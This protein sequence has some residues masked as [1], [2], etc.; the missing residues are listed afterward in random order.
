MAVNSDSR[1]RLC[2]LRGSTRLDGLCLEFCEGV[3]YGYIRGEG[4][5]LDMNLDAVKLYV[6]T[7]TPMGNFIKM[8]PF[9]NFGTFYCLDCIV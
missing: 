5:Y 6:H 3:G 8:A 9:C 7:V 1:E 2:T 4:I